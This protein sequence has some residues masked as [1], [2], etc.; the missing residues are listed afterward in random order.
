MFFYAFAAYLVSALVEL[1]DIPD[2]PATPTLVIFTYELSVE[3]RGRDVA[4]N[5]F[6]Q[7]VTDLAVGVHLFVLVQRK[8]QF[9]F[10]LDS[11]C[12]LKDRLQQVRVLEVLFKEYV[13]V[14]VFQDNHHFTL[15]HVVLQALDQQQI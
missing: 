7:F 4:L 10:I 15:N 3:P 12:R 9:C 5:H 11:E 8:G 2:D 1:V 14:L 6:K 13:D